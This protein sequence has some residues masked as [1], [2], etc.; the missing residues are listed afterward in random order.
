MVAASVR[1]VA[2]AS[3]QLAE[4]FAGHLQHGGSGGVHRGAAQVRQQPVAVVLGPAGEGR[5]ADRSTDP[6]EAALRDQVAPAL[7][8]DVGREP[9]DSG[10]QS[11][12]IA[13]AIGGRKPEGLIYEMFLDEKGAPQMVERAYILPPQGQIG[14]I[15]SEE[16]SQLIRRSLIYGVYEKLIDRES[17]YEILSERQDL[18][19]IEQQRAAEEKAAIAKQRELE[20][21]Q[22]EAERIERA[23]QRARKAQG[24][25]LLDDLI[26]QVGRST[27][28]QISNQVGRTITRTIFGTFFG[29]K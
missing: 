19:H 2:R 24:G 5:L 13:K 29:K 17:A 1:D 22:R 26:K 21:A 8:G 6:V 16:R 3:R 10:V 27:S 23:E 9:A 12:K 28:R 18:L 4:L 15:T 14:P 20:K 11:G 25:G 7:H